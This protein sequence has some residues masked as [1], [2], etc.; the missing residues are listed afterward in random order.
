MEDLRDMEPFGCLRIPVL[1]DRE[2]TATYK[3][4]SWAKLN[5]TWGI[6]MYLTFPETQEPVEMPTVTLLLN[7]P[8][9]DHEGESNIR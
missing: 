2:L 8:S 9:K 6:S 7:V 1:C 5:K 3:A 4:T